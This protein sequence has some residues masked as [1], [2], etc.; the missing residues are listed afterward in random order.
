MTGRLLAYLLWFVAIA[1]LTSCATAA[2]YEKILNSWTGHSEN[3][4]LSSWGPPDSAYESGDTKYLTYA[5]G[6][7]VVLP[8]TA[9]SYR[10]VGNTMYP[11]GGT[12]PLVINK[13]CKTTFIVQSSAIV[14]WRWEGN[15]CKA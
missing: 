3:E 10:S 1:A 15:A 2:N 7:T 11:V 8:G 14:S 4:L 5:R 9:P 12:P 13:H 6:G